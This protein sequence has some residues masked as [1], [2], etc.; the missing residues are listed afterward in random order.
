M[1]VFAIILG[2]LIFL[3]GWGIFLVS[4]G[5]A[6]DYKYKKDEQDKYEKWKKGRYIGLIIFAIGLV[7]LIIVM[8]SDG[9]FDGGSS[10]SLGSDRCGVCNK[11]YSDSTNVKSIHR[12]NMCSK[13]NKNYKY[14]Q[15]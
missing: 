2:F 11:T 5:N 7:I 4:H 9:V 15:N 13:C 10:S 8:S 12:T 14:H 1:R 6:K 3:I